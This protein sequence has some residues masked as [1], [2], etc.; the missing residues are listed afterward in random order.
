M[1]VAYVG[2]GS[3]LGDR[4]GNIKKALG[5]LGRDANVCAVSS[6]YETE[7]EG[8]ED[9]DWF[10]NAVAQIET[11]LSPDELLKLFKNIELTIGRRET[12]RW[13]PREIDIDL[14]LYDQICLDTPELI[15]PHRH[16]HKRAFVLVPLAEIGADVR[17]P[18]L[19]KTVK[20]ILAELQKAGD[21]QLSNDK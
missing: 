13:G 17:H 7:P 19:N 16:M 15:V 18:I 2:L 21:V 12:I 5:M 3:N 6:M 4:K 11:S 1:A 8:Y 20:E 9:Q 14:L 10:I